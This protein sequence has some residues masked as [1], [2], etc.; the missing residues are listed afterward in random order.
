MHL[1]SKVIAKCSSLDLK[2]KIVYDLESKKIDFGII[3]INGRSPLFNAQKN[4]DA[5]MIEVLLNKNLN[6][7]L[8]DKYGITP[9]AL[10]VKNASI[11]ILELYIS[12][13]AIINKPLNYH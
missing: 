11:H 2:R 3:D 8:V 7:N 12:K 10:A 1:L 13:G 4:Y 6:P 5:F 9:L